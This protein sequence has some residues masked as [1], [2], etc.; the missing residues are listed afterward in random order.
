MG[1]WSL[2]M[3][4]SMS[5]LAGVR[6]GECS[7]EPGVGGDVAEGIAYESI[8]SIRLRV[9]VAMMGWRLEFALMVL[10]VYF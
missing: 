10:K 7:S 4:D 3:K 2:G 1:S 5:M 8:I 6:V 9:M